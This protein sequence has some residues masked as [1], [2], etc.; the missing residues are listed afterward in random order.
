MLWS[1][2]GRFHFDGSEWPISRLKFWYRGHERMHQEESA[3]IEA[4][5]AAIN[6]KR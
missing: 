1:V 2:G 3:A 6:G 4:A 5:K